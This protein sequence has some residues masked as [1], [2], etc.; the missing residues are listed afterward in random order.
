[1]RRR[2]KPI[3]PLPNSGAHSARFVVEAS[4]SSYRTCV[5]T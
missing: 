5:A 4:N 3:L 1:V 2:A